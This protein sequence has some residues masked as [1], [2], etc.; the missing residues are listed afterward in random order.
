MDKVQKKKKKK[1]ASVNFSR[2]LFS[3]LD[4]VTLKIGPIDCPAS[5]VKN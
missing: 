3:L 2:A 1:T 5:S 4:F